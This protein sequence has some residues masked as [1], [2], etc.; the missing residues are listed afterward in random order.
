MSVLGQT[1]RDLELIIVIDGATD[2]SYEVAVRLE[3]ADDRVSVWR[4][5]VNRGLAV[6]QNIGITAA[7]SPWVMKVDA[8]DYIAPTYVE[9]ILLAAEQDP[10]ANVIFSPCQHVGQRTDVYRYP[11]YDARRVAD[12]FMIAGCAAVKR[13]VWEAVGG[14]DETMRCAEDWDFYV[15][16]ERAVGLVPHQLKE[17]R[18]CYRVHDGPRMSNRGR[19]MLGELQAYWRGHTKES[20]LAR[21]RTWGAWCG[22]KGLAA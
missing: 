2:D 8:D 15:R 16:A 12:A 7:Q 1:E 4:N 5:R 10:R 11:L 9:D 19:S 6:S 18:W 21:S 3:E 20:V 14:L 13:S 17:P 22:A